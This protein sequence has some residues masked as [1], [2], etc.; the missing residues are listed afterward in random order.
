MRA[1]QARFRDT[2]E[3][4]ADWFW[5]MDQDLRFTYISSGIGSIDLDRGAFLG[6]TREDGLGAKYDAGNPDAE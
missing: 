1:S 3:M 4:S 2:A 5:E 6:K